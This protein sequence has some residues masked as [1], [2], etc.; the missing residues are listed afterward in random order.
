MI[1]YHNG[2]VLDSGCELICHQVNLQGVFGGGLARAI[3][4]KYPEV[5][6]KYTAF[7]PKELGQ[8]CIVKAKDG[9]LIANLFTQ[10][11]S[12]NTNYIRLNS[13]LL[14]VLE[15]AKKKGIKTIGIPYKYGC[16]IAN[17]DWDIVELTFKRVFND[18]DIDLQI[19]RLQ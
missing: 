6:D 10:D 17:G 3:G 15:Y 9:T 1:T 13:C 8:A 7:E 14:G 5:E 11:Y 19:W 16:G 12:F 18:T 2:S 4:N